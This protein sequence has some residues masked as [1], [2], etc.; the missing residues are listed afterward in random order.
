MSVAELIAALQLLEQQGHR[1]KTILVYA[2]VDSGFFWSYFNIETI[3]LNKDGDAVI[4]DIE[5]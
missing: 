5:R 1:E 2:P 3:G 4:L